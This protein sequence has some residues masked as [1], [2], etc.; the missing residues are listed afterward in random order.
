MSETYADTTLEGWLSEVI[1]RVPAS[2]IGTLDLT[3]LEPYRAEVEANLVE[4][5]ASDDGEGNRLS[6]DEWD[7]GFKGLS[8]TLGL[9]R[10]LHRM[11]RRS[12]EVRKAI[13][14][15]EREARQELRRAR[16]MAHKE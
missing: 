4:W 10:I 7:R 2:V 15:R 11:A 5:A 16:R 13:R 1:F 12:H 3:P 8:D 6:L 14:A 9:K